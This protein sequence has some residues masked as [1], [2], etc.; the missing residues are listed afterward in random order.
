MSLLDDIDK[1]RFPINLADDE[2]RIYLQSL[3]RIARALAANAPGVATPRD[4]IEGTLT[5]DLE[6]GDTLPQT[7]G[8]VSY[9]INGKAIISGKK[10]SSGAAYGAIWNGTDHTM[11][12]A[13]ECHEDA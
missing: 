3:H 4:Y 9:T 2:L 5:G 7:I 1:L 13:N 11:I 10:I 12:W 8:G 6:S